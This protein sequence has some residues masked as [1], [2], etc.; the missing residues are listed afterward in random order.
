MDQPLLYRFVQEKLA[1]EGH[2][3]IKEFLKTQVAK[4]AKKIL[5]QGC[6]TGE[7]A[8]LFPNRYIGIDNNNKDIIFARKRYQGKFFTCTATKMKFKDNSF[9]IVFSVGLYHHLND[10][11]AKKAIKE[12]VRVT[13]TK[14]KVIIIDAM[15]PKNQ[16]NLIGLIL[17]KLDR[18][19]Y[20]RR[21]KDTM[22]LIPKGLEFSS[23]IL[24]SFP[25]DYI[26]ITIKT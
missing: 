4:T 20:V 12:A 3:V 19:G 25:F 10:D 21:Y 18:G 14:G 24:S 13:R 15:L 17:R 6:G 1:G 26:A 11:K 5:D 22:K 23:L 7:Y 16:F 9:D 2:S 8:L